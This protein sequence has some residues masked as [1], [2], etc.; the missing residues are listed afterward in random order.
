MTSPAFPPCPSNFNLTAHVLG[1][2]DARPDKI[3]LAVVKPTGAE[4]WSYARLK[5]AVLGCATGLLQ[6]GLQPGDRL[7]MRVGNTVDFP[8]AYLAAIA[9]GIVPIPTSTQLTEAEVQVLIDITA[10]AAVLHDGQ[11]DCP[12]GVRLIR[13]QD[14]HEWYGLPPAAYDPGD[15]NRLAYIIFTSGT[16]GT[17]RAVCHAHRA[18]W[19][20]GMMMDG[21]YGLHEDDRLMHAGAFNWTY[22]LGTGLLDPWTKGATALIPAQ[23][24]EHHQLPLLLKRHEATIFAAAPG[25]YRN[26]LKSSSI[27]LPKLRHGLSAGEK[28][29]A[30]IRDAWQNA[31]GTRLFEAFGMSECSTFISTNPKSPEVAPQSLGWPQPGRRVTILD[32]SGPVD[33]GHP[34]IIAI[35]KSDP[36]LMLGYLNDQIATEHRY[37]GDWFLTGDMGH[38]TPQGDIHYHGRAD[39]MMNAGGYRVSPIEVETAL[40]AH[41]DIA[42]VGVTDIEIKQDIRVIAAFYVADRPLDEDALKNWASNRLAR[43]KQPR[44]FRRIAAL[45]RN[46]NGKLLRK[47]L[48]DVDAL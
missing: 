38:M 10:P 20:R 40:L 48:P 47:T 13:T 26:V 1:Q 8:V 11:T 33:S 31:T 14:T 6:S 18:I 46:A 7:L 5:S 9:V 15:P 3:A 43:Y 37:Q 17:P 42:E 44:L 32:D 19:A 30:S 2:A 12:P 29:P 27:D 25:V 34:G 24:V 28:L 22:T 41:P 16:S 45:P 4:R 23:G 35:H 21:W 39:D 36:G